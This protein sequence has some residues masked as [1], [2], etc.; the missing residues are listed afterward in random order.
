MQQTRFKIW[1]RPSWHILKDLWYL[2]ITF[3]TNVKWHH[4]PTPMPAV[5][6]CKFCR[7]GRQTARRRQQCLCPAGLNKPSCG[8]WVLETD[9]YNPG[10]SWSIL[11]LLLLAAVELLQA[12]IPV[13]KIFNKNQRANW[14]Q[15]W[16]WWAGCY[17][18]QGWSAD[19]PQGLPS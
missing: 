2:T 17:S 11:E 1:A 16:F 18:A 7:E 12:T 14:R 8:T 5:H 3:L 19:F 10:T 6:G 15:T 13:R 4:N 9:P